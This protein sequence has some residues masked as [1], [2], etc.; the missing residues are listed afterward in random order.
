MALDLEEQEQL[1][2]FKAWW[3]TNGKILMTLLG[4]ALIGYIAYIGWQSHVS[5]QSLEASN[6]FIAL[7]ALDPKDTKAIQTAAT[8]IMDKFAGAKNL[9][10][11]LK[12]THPKA[13][14]VKKNYKFKNKH[15]IKHR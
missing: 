6:A 14:I 9:I 12:I 3:K 10:D 5:K 13:N 8:S 1:D 4:A 2:E 7:T 11:E 15:N